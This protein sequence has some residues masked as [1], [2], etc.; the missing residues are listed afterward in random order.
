MFIAPSVDLGISACATAATVSPAMLSIAV[1]TLPLTCR[2]LGFQVMAISPT[3]QP[4]L[5]LH[6]HFRRDHEGRT[7][8][9]VRTGLGGAMHS[10]PARALASAI[11]AY[12][13]EMQRREDKEC[14]GDDY[15]EDDE[16]APD[17]LERWHQR[18]Q[19]TGSRR[20]PRIGTS[21]QTPTFSTPPRSA[22]SWRLRTSS[23]LEACLPVQA[24]TE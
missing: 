3:E 13:D 12:A 23:V 16:V 1:I 11:S 18:R 24:A 2:N 4:V 5:P 10:R 15:D 14:Y 20:R 7:L 17:G 19:V 8:A 6:Q 21:P 22:A 9:H